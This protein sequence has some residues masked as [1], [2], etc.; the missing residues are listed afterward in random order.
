MALCE[1]KF[2]IWLTKKLT[3]RK[4]ANNL[5]LDFQIYFTNILNGV[6]FKEFTGIAVI[7]ILFL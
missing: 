3:M 1:N 2:N 7:T 6:K 5:L 4:K